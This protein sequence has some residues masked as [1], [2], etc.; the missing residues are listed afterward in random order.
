MF[1]ITETKHRD[2]YRYYL[3]RYGAKGV[4]EPRLANDCQVYRRV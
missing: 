3:T 2:K 4:C 1:K